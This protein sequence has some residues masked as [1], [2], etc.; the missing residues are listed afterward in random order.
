VVIIVIQ[1]RLSFENICRS[2]SYLWKI[3]YSDECQTP[4]HLTCCSSRAKSDVGYGGFSELQ[5]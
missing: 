4:I 5:G 1:L 3:V 2:A